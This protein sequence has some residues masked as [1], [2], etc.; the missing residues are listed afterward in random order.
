[1][2][3][4]GLDWRPLLLAWLHKRPA[5]EMDVLRNCF[6]SS[7]AAIYQWSRQNLIYKMDVLECNIINQVY[8]AVTCS[9]VESVIT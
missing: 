4:S 5:F 6:E 1:M 3:S 7:F 2:S 8:Q 9:I